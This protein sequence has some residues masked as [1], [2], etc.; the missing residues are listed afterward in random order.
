ME[1]MRW[2]LPILLI[3]SALGCRT[4]K[5]VVELVVQGDEKEL[6]QRKPGTPPHS[7]DHPKMLI[8]ML[9]G[10]GRDTLY[11]ELERGSMPNLARLIGLERKGAYL[12]DSVLTTFPSTTMVAWATGL[13]GVFAPQHGVAG[14]EYFVRSR[15]TYVAPAPVSTGGPDRSIANFT[16][17]YL[18]RQ[19]RTQTTWERLR[20]EDPEVLIWVAMHPIYRGADKLLATS[21][22]TLLSAFRGFVE[23]NIAGSS[24][25][26]LYRVLDEEVA[27]EITDSLAEA[28]PLPDV[29]AIYLAGTDLYA[30]QAE[31][32]PDRA[33]SDYLHEITDPLIGE[34]A[35]QLGPR[36]LANRFVIVTSDHGHTRVPFD[37]THALGNDTDAGD[38]PAL[39]VDAG[40]RVR[41][42]EFEVADDHDF[43]AAVAYQGATA[44]IYLA[45]RSLCSDPGTAC[46]W[47]K[48]PRYREDILAAAESFHRTNQTGQPV[49]EMKGSLEVILVRNRNAGRFE[50]YVGDGK[51]S[52]VADGNYPDAYVRFAERLEQLTRGRYGDHAGDIILIARNATEEDDG[53]RFYFDHKY[54]SWH[55]SPSLRDSAIPFI[56]YHPQIDRGELE[57]LVE[58]LDVG[59][60]RILDHTIRRIARRYRR[61]Q[62]R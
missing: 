8:L 9:D 12:A 60:I 6:Y 30:H 33:L 31:K 49:A 34:I 4:T 39:L 15:R 25:R 19:L 28:D 10:V 14:N 32:G 17:S 22:K 48:S 21:R 44:Y 36:D 7:P 1:P 27:D 42:F 3:C 45:D 50:V 57:Q 24:A 5:E 23:V 62:G 58:E 43:N 59:D 53:R 29:L 52:P 56:V 2:L 13:T 18:N 20:G 47:R 16:D 35:D 37:G 26:D 55:G 51:T 40:F 61:S 11:S 41:P 46:N 38:P 54:R